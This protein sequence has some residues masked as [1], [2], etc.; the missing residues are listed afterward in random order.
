MHTGVFSALI[1]VFASPAKSA[2]GE[3]R[4][5]KPKFIVKILV[6]T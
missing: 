4:M 5:L 3:H 2:G 6:E 1:Q